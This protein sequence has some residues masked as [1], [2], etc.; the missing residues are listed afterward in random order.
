MRLGELFGVRKEQGIEGLPVLSV[1]INQGMIRRDALKRKMESTLAPNEHLLVKKGDISYNMMRMWQG[2]LGAAHEDGLISPAYVVCTPREGVCSEYFA[3]LFRTPLLL[4]HFQD[5]AYGITGDRLRLYFRDFEKIRADIPP[6]IEQKKIANLFNFWDN[7]ITLTE[8]L[9]AEKQL[10]RK[11]LM[12][13]LLTGKRRLPGFDGEWREVCLGDIFDDRTDA[14]RPDL[15][16]ISITAGRGTILRNEINRKDNSNTDKQKYLHIRPG[17]IGYNTMRMWQGIS[18]LSTLEGIV[19]PAYT[20]VTP[21]DGID[22]QFMA[23]LF[24]FPP[25]IH[26]FYRYSQGLVSDTWNLKFRHFSEIK[27]AIPKENEQR[28]IASVFKTIDQEIKLLQ[29]KADALRK[30]KK[31]MMQQLLTGKKRVE[32]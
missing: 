6:Y 13:K 30:Q 8:K 1:T 26:L 24:K 21:K 2:A 14:G 15:P 31:G 25:V 18:A 16:L 5:Y 20:I 28:A 4:K 32:M 29:A 7:A 23:I 19:S 9:I 12:Q 11:G 17:D 10:R 22:G 27:L 3:H